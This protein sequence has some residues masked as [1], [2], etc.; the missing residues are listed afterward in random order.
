MYDYI[1]LDDNEVDNRVDIQNL[2]N[3][4]FESIIFP[5][6]NLPPCFYNGS[7]SENLDYIYNSYSNDEEI[8]TENF[9]WNNGKIKRFYGYQD[10][11]ARV[12]KGVEPINFIFEKPSG[13]PRIFSIAQYKY[14]YINI[15]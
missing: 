6:K 14:H 5:N 4:S 1:D 7:I 9:E 13:G 12:T 3:V 2:V 8:L 15:Y 10:I 11:S